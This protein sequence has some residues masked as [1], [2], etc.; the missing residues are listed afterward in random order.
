MNGEKKLV[1]IVI[2]VAFQSS[3]QGQIIKTNRIGTYLIPLLAYAANPTMLLNKGSA[4]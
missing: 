4:Q 3:K 1:K 2:I